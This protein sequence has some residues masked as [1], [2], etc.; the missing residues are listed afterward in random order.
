MSVAF[1]AAP[2]INRTRCGTNGVGSSSSASSTSSGIKNQ[3]YPMR[4]QWG[5]VQLQRSQHF[6]RTP[7]GEGGLNH[8][9]EGY[10]PFFN[11]IDPAM[12]Y[13]VEA[14]RHRAPPAGIMQ[15][16]TDGVDEDLMKAYGA[17][18]EAAQ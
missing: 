16:L 14:L 7:S 4:Y 11:H 2:S 12:K 8:L 6:I 3:P 10:R 17:G 5:G 13:M 9:C 1:Q 15:V 18:T